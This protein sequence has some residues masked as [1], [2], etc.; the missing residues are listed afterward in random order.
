MR[1]ATTALITTLTLF[2][3]IGAASAQ[4]FT[5]CD[6]RYTKLNEQLSH[7]LM[8][9]WQKHAYSAE[10]GG[11]YQSCKAGQPESWMGIDNKIND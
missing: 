7:R 3:V 10:L 11:D 5:A 4:D 8:P 2:S 1:I 9:S 6:Q